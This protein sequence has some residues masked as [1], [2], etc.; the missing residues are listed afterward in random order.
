MTC[1]TRNN[2]ELYGSW[3]GW[4]R[5]PRP[6]GQGV[7]GVRL[8]HRGEAARRP[9]LSGLPRPPRR[10]RPAEL[11]MRGCRACSPSC[12][13]LALGPPLS[14]TLDNNII[15]MRYLPGRVASPPTG[16]SS[17]VTFDSSL[18]FMALICSLLT[19]AIFHDRVNRR[20]YILLPESPMDLICF[21]HKAIHHISHKLKA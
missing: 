16:L 14:N 1:Y 9:L 2:K 20:E 8:T 4:P 6:A 11:L 13:S 10:H 21:R 12:S 19:I 7:E 5:P 18:P 17:S 3:T 15:T